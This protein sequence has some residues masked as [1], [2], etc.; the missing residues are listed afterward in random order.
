MP[1]V[2]PGAFGMP[3]DV[4]GVITRVHGE[5]MVN[6][7]VVPDSEERSVWI[8]SVRY[9]PSREESEHSGFNLRCFPA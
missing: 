5:R 4:A 7:K 2:V 8:T 9:D 6:V 1:V 3:E